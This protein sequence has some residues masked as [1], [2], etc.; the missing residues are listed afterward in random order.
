MGR[1]MLIGLVAGGFFSATFVL[2]RV[3][4]LG[5]GH[6]F[7][8]GALRYGYMLVFLGIG[9]VLYQSPSFFKALIRLYFRY[10]LFWVIAGSIGFGC[11]YALICFS[12][13]HSPGWVVATTWQLTI[14][15]SLFV[16]RGFGRQF[17]KKI[18]AWAL[19][20]FSGV[21]LVNLGE[22][23]VHSIE[24]LILGG[25]PVLGAAFCYPLGNQLVWEA[26]F[27]R[28]WIPR[29]NDPILDNAFAK[30]WLM[31]AGTIPF[32][33]CLY[34]VISPGAPSVGQWGNTALVALLSGVVATT[35]FI[36]ARGKADSPV[37]LAAVDATQSSEVIFALAGEVVFLSACLP[38]LP[39]MAG[40]V[41]TLV[42][43]SGM[44]K[45]GEK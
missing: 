11:F 8:S 16:L 4:S 24:T 2:N 28:Q 15:A 31:S 5:G 25:L 1:L 3:M 26:K 38:G 17:P 30:V 21:C 33:F 39:G 41:I 45:S 29:I 37:K 34:F 6:W 27:G 13:D 36:Y 12:A 43:L 9:L 14:I 7:W 20:V 40:I 42:G 35:L 19:V 22:S 32:W 18:W 10:F 44:A 23:Q